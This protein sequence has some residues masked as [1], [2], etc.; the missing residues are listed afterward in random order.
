MTQPRSIVELR[1]HTIERGI[2]LTDGASQLLANA[3]SQTCRTV[4]P[5]GYN[6]RERRRM[7]DQPLLASVGPWEG[8]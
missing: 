4:A 2:Y 3:A 8:R 6:R 7:W 5:A 1:Q